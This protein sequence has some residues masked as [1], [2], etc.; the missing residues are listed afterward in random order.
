MSNNIG[1]HP[2]DSRVVNMRRRRRGSN[3]CPSITATGASFSGLSTYLGRLHTRMSAIST[4][5]PQYSCERTTYGRPVGQGNNFYRIARNKWL[6]PGVRV[7][8]LIPGPVLII[9]KLP[10]FRN[11]QRCADDDGQVTPRRPLY[12]PSLI[13]RQWKWFRPASL[14][15]VL[16]APY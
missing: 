9:P 14:V 10:S 1:V 13:W 5:D 16:A 6:R 7:M 8:G 15:A 2:D 12:E 3:V 11:G 4:G